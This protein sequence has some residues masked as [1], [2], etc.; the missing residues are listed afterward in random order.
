MEKLDSKTVA[1]AVR[2]WV[3]ANALIELS[4]DSAE[5]RITGW[6]VHEAF[7]KVDRSTRQ[8]WLWDGM[9][10]N[11][12]LKPWKGLRGTFGELATQIGLV[13][14][15]SPTEYENAFGESAQTA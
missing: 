2:E 3:G 9:S 15:F 4:R 1:E 11:Q 13:L 6:I 7:A 5:G 14:S 12:L 8:T 10:G